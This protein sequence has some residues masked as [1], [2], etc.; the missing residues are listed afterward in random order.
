MV[1]SFT[2]SNVF[3]ET[4]YCNDVFYIESG[5]ILLEFIRLILLLSKYFAVVL[6]IF[7]TIIGVINNMLYLVILGGVLLVVFIVSMLIRSLCNM[8]LPVF[9]VQLTYFRGMMFMVIMF[10]LVVM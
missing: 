2:F 1:E 4:K 10:V 8:I 9:L 3:P 5:V 7:C 6:M